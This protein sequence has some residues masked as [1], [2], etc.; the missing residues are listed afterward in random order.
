MVVS[1]VNSVNPKTVVEVGCG[2]GDILSRVRAARR[3]G[4]DS[5][6]EVIR[7]ARVLHPLK[8]RWIYG[9]ANCVPHVIPASYTIDCMIMVNWI[10]NLSAEQ[11]ALLLM[12]LLPR[13]RYL[14][15]DAIHGDATG[16]RFKHDF[17]F[18]AAMAE[19]VA[20]LRPQA[21]PRDLV[22]FKVLK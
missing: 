22:L 16:Y 19:R 8:A 2:L 20:V 14:V 17:S 11:L 12:P 4:I 18:L 13:V 6:R 7:A 5:D 15:M 21:E 1:L 3:F 9:D 10:H